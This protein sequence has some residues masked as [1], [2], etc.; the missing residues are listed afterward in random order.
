MRF[1]GPSGAGGSALSCAASQGPGVSL[2]QTRDPANAFLLWNAESITGEPDSGFSKRRVIRTVGG[3]IVIRQ[4]DLRKHSP[5][6]GQPAFIQLPG[7]LS[8]LN[9]YPS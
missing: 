8:T 6:R 2:G 1:L 9:A 7:E 3:P 5:H 4:L